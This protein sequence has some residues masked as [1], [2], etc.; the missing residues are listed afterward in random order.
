M[1]KYAVLI[2]LALL[3]IAGCVDQQAQQQAE[4]QIL[5]QRFQAAYPDNWQQKL[6]E[7][8]IEQQREAWR[9]LQ[10]LQQVDTHNDNM[11]DAYMRGV[12]ARRALEQQK[13]A[14]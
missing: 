13:L 8:D 12:M 14:K 1:K 7:Y 11:A 10:Q 2:A 5:V 4:R 3:F 6:L 9:S